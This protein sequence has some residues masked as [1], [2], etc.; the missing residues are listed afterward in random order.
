MLAVVNAGCTTALTF[1]LTFC[2]CDK[3]SYFAKKSI[4]LVTR[5]IILYVKT[6]LLVWL[7]LLVVYKRVRDIHQTIL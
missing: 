3:L 4:L 1:Q 2:D 7:S 5:K 6:L